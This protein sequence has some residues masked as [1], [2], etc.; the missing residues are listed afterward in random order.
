MRTIQVM[1]MMTSFKP[2]HFF[3]FLI[4]R[5][6]LNVST[7]VSTFVSTLFTQISNRQH[8]TLQPIMR[9]SCTL[10]LHLLLLLSPLLLV[11]TT[12]HTQT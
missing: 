5:S 10:L 1:M 2:H 9:E 6:K 7:K 3:L 11:A 8:E 12:T 4:Q